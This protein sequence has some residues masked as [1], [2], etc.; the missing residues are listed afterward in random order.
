MSGAE[1]KPKWEVNIKG[2]PDRIPFEISVV[3]SDYELKRS[4]GW[5]GEH[6]LL[7]SHNCG[8]WSVNETIWGE[9]TGVADRIADELNNEIVYD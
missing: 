7:I 3:R 5:F 2:G 8:P 9:L 1:K 4:Y 6:K